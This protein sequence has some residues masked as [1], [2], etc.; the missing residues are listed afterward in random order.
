[1]E[2][3]NNGIWDILEHNKT[4]ILDLTKYGYKQYFTVMQHI[5]NFSHNKYFCIEYKLYEGCKKSNCIKTAEK[6]EYF[7]PSIN[8]TEEI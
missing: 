4:I 8:I 2:N 7:S 1:M 6:T 5:Q 3:L